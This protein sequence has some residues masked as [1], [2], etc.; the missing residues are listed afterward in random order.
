MEKII[1]ITRIRSENPTFSGGQLGRK[2]YPTWD[3]GRVE[4]KATYLDDKKKQKKVRKYPPLPK[5]PYKFGP[6][7]V[8][9]HI[10]LPVSAS[11][12]RSF[13]FLLL[14]FSHQNYKIKFYFSSSSLKFNFSDPGKY[15]GDI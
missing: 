4:L 14:I 15:V 2:Y 10:P 13:F 9:S 8:N 5:Q 1:I 3:P 6:R 12:L 11:E 7:I